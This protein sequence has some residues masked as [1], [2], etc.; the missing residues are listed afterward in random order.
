MY[1]KIRKHPTTRSLYARRLVAE[2]VLGD[3]DDKRIMD[4]YRAALERGDQVAL[5]I[6]A[7]P[8]KALHVDWTPYL[9]H[10]WSEYA[11][12]TVDAHRLRELANKMCEA[13]DGIVM[14]RQVQKIYE[15][16]RLMAAA[17]TPVNWGFAETLAYATLLD[18]DHP[19]R[20]TGQDVGRGTFSHRHVVLHSQKDGETWIPLQ[21]LRENQPD[22]WI[23]DSL[24]SEMAVLGFE[25]G[26]ATTTPNALIIWEA[27]FGDFANNAQVVID[28][29]I[30][31]GEHKWQRLCGLTLLL[32]HGY[33]GQGPEHSSA[34]LER[35]L[36]L[37]AEHNIQVCVPTTPAQIF[38]LLRRQVI[39]PL[40]KPLVVISPKSLLR[41]KEAVSEF[42]ELA[43]G[44]FQ[45]V[46]PETDEQNLKKVTR[47]VLCSGKVYYELR[48]RRRELE[49]DHV[50]IVRIEQLYPFPEQD[51]ERALKPYKNLLEVVWCQEEPQN[52]GA[53]YSSQHHMR[54][55][56][57]RHKRDLYLEYAGRE[58]AASPAAGYTA[59][60]LTQQEQLIQDALGTQDPRWPN[61]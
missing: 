30:T 7:N 22:F 1:Q 18:A 35:F 3:D 56:I 60:H 24:L 44:T 4:D 38:H 16:R 42:D 52:Q 31:S 21:H 40:R 6:V 19:V 36:Q 45:N 57:A 25:Y 41:H 34:R 43:H 8:N 27:Q 15:D 46:I 51:L 59:L 26:Y 2:G 14:Q 53:W 61:N 50:A 5:H 37:S 49:L 29:F 32:P 23:Y 55:I 28:Q 17:A 9:G 39:R 47:L 48:Q 33:E 12:T 58:A 11:D 10:T 54:R 13:H 20:I